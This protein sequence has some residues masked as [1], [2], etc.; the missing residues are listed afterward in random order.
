ML[1]KGKN[2]MRL[3]AIAGFVRSC[4]C[5]RLGFDAIFAQ[6]DVI[7]RHPISWPLGQ[8]YREFKGIRRFLGLGHF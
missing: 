8:K 4:K 3:Q 6:F 5:G 2:S 1:G 7:E